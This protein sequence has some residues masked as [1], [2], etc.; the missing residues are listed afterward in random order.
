MFRFKG[1]LQQKKNAHI[2]SSEDNVKLATP[3]PFCLQILK[4]ERFFW[5]IF[6]PVQ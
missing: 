2:L 3:P 5:F 6:S 1:R 4:N